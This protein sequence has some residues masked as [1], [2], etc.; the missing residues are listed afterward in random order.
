[1]PIQ[2]IPG[3]RDVA[4][5]AVTISMSRSREEEARLKAALLTENI[6]SAAVDFGGEFVPSIIRIIERTVIA[7]KREWHYQRKPFGGRR[8]SR[9]GTRS[10]QPDHHQSAG[11][12]R[13]REDRHRPA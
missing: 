1:M 5:A 7:S 13:R 3:S 4:R 2:G 12:E 6:H 10:A 11:H 8:R 9:R